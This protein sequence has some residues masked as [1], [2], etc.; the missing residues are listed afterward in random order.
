MAPKFAHMA[1]KFASPLSPTASFLPPLPL[2]L[3][4]RWP[5]GA[6]AVHVVPLLAPAVLG[7][8]RQLVLLTSIA[9]GSDGCCPLAQAQCIHRPCRC[10]FAAGIRVM[11]LAMKWHRRNC[12]RACPMRGM[13]RAAMKCAGATPLLFT[14]TLV[15]PCMCCAN[16]LQHAAAQTA[17][18]AW[19]A[20]REKSS[21]FRCSEHTLRAFFPGF[22][23]YGASVCRQSLLSLPPP[24]LL[25]RRCGL[26]AA[27][28][29]RPDVVSCHL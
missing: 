25:L 1:P 18:T 13:G 20:G 7:G 23:V 12:N 17:L 11:E 9:V 8:T 15:K 19:L 29:C 22:L 26:L 16:R 14:S 21:S 5:H 28:G 10:R 4:Y 6:L 27:S 2:S 3:S 24:T